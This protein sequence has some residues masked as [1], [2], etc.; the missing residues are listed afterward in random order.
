MLVSGKRRDTVQW[1]RE[2]K[3]WTQLK[4]VTKYR[5]L[6]MLVPLMLLAALACEGLE[7]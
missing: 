7:A 6:S 2:M 5:V 1:R 3:R 4:T